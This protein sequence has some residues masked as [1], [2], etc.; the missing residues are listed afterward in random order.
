MAT[1]VMVLTAPEDRTFTLQAQEKLIL[2]PVFSAWDDQVHTLN[3]TLAGEGAEVEVIGFFIGS[4][5]HAI[6]YHLTFEHQAPR[7]K[8]QALFRGLLSDRSKVDFHGNI[9]I[10]PRAVHTDAYLRHNTLLLSPQ[11]HSTSVP[12]LEILAD[13]VKVGHAS[14]TGTLD[15]ESVFYLMSRGLNQQ[16]AKD[17]LVDAFIHEA[18]LR[19]PDE[20]AREAAEILINQALR[21]E[22]AG[23]CGG[24]CCT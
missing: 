19:I 14:T 23:C 17:T 13:D 1:K 11:A 6:R 16:Q 7:T 24:G 12:A 20:S 4:G 3:V 15:P 5:E 18:I 2:V 22:A 9:N 10:S 21:P 8:S